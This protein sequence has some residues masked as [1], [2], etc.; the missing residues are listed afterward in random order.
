MSTP[1][2]ASL[3]VSPPPSTGYI[4][5]QKLLCWNSMIW[6]H[7]AMHFTGTHTLILWCPVP[8][9][10][11]LAHQSHQSAPHLPLVL[12]ASDQHNTGKVTLDLHVARESDSKKKP[13]HITRPT[14]CCYCIATCWPV[15]IYYIL[16]SPHT[17]LFRFLLSRHFWSLANKQSTRPAT[18]PG[19]TTE[20][21]SKHQQACTH[22]SA[23]PILLTK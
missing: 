19:H 1:R 18:P 14:L 11:A 20:Q 15:H 7:H 6:Y 16:F 17:F 22:Y 9:F 4:Q 2:A 5:S 10:L 23:L 13:S 12:A 21:E 8:L 3:V